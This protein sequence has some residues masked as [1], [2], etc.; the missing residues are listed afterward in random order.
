MYRFLVEG[1]ESC[2][3]RGRQE[4]S[5]KFVCTTPVHTTPHKILPTFTPHRRNGACSRIVPR[6]CGARSVKRTVSVDTLR[7]P[8]SE[9]AKCSRGCDDLPSAPRALGTVLE[10]VPTLTNQ[11]MEWCRLCSRQKPHVPPAFYGLGDSV[12][13]PQ[14]GRVVSRIRVG[15][16]HDFLSR[17][18]SDWSS[19]RPSARHSTCMIRMGRGAEKPPPRPLPR[20]ARP[21]SP[22]CAWPQRDTRPALFAGIASTISSIGTSGRSALGTTCSTADALDALLRPARIR[23][24]ELSSEATRHAQRSANGFRSACRPPTI[25]DHQPA[26]PSARPPA[27]PSPSIPPGSQ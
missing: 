16:H 14:R 22:P 24:S 7:V 1:G 17:R 20:L 18:V 21:P 23:I 3:T 8:R 6:S 10:R 19:R 2:V 5:P 9:A 13:P 12:L 15:L 26:A 11:C 4:T 27:C 25:G